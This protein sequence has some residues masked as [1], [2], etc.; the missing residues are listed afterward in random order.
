V[1]HR[2]PIIAAL[3]VLAAPGVHAA[4]SSPPPRCVHFVY[5]IRH[6]LYDRD[7]LA[8][9]RVGNGLNA[10]GREQ[11]RLVGARLKALP[12]KMH[13]LVSSDFTRAR[14]TAAIVGEA[15]GIKPTLDSLIRECTPAS[16]RSDLMRAHTPESFARCDST[17]GAAWRKYASPTPDADT[18]DVLVCHGNVIRW[19]VTRAMD[20]DTRQWAN[21]DIGNGSLTVLAVRP[22]GTTRLVMF[23][24]VGH[25]P[26]DKQT[27]S[28]R[29]AGWGAPAGR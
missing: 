15:L 14:E 28:G 7:S 3:L 29:G 6:G 22:D 25:I 21:M 10:L 11:A 8:D 13:A 18:H 9:D 26:V 19:F 24:D 27:W 12:V 4:D 16:S 23:S 2:L 5:L 1:T 20:A 17:L